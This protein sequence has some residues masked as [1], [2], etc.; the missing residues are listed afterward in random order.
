LTNPIKLRKTLEQRF[1]C[2]TAVQQ[3]LFKYFEYKSIT[4]KMTKILN[5][6][7]L[8]TVILVL[9]VTACGDNKKKKAVQSVMVKTP[10]V[11]EELSNL[12]PDMTLNEAI[13]VLEILQGNTDYDTFYKGLKSAQIIQTLDSLDVVTIFAPSNIAF[14]RITEKKLTQLTTPEGKEEMQHILGYHIVQDEYDYKT[15]LSTVRL[16]ENV[17]RLKTLN[18]GYIA[19]SIENDTLF[20]TDE[21]GFQSEIT[22][23]DQEA[24]NGVIHGIS[25]LLLAQ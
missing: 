24:E 14:N 10:I 22:E 21:T 12:P 4:P 18:G 25:A 19:L 20:I 11:E 1:E 6:S 2:F 8:T 7:W 13:S 23:P 5:T 17:L 16:N 9:L 3:E 15:L